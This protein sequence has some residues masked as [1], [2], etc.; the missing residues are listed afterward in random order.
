VV[1]DGSERVGWEV[2]IQL[3]EAAV[4]RV[5]ELGREWRKALDAR[6]ERITRTVQAPLLSVVPVR[7]VRAPLPASFVRTVGRASVFRGRIGSR[8][9]L[10]MPLAG[11]VT[12]V[13]Q[14]GCRTLVV[15][16]HDVNGVIHES[17][18]G[19]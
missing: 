3:A 1:Q 15:A 11:P 19:L 7:A 12:R 13:T 9:G 8:L 6:R 14:C 5:A 16:R 17:T 10:P 4:E 18:P 2:E